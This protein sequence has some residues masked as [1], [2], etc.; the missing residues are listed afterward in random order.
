MCLAR[1]ADIPVRSN[2]LCG[3]RATN[4]PRLA[5]GSC[6]GQECPR[7]AKQ[8]LP[9]WQ[10]WAL[11][12]DLK[13]TSRHDVA[14]RVGRM[15]KSEIPTKIPT[16]CRDSVGVPAQKTQACQIPCHFGRI[17]ETCNLRKGR[18]DNDP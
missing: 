2:G 3:E 15:A 16:N 17:G 1:S 7:S 8:V 13:A 18:P 6:C 4:R 11:D 10:D 14:I 12:P 9:K 5:F